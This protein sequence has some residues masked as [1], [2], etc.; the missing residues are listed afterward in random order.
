MRR[1][2]AVLFVHIG[3]SDKYRG[4]AVEGG[5]AFL[6]DDPAHR[7][8]CGEARLFEPDAQGFFQCGIGRH[9]VHADQAD[10]DIIFVA[11]DL[12]G[13]YRAVAAFFGA[14]WQP[15]PDDYSSEWRVA[16]ARDVVLLQTSMRPKLEWPFGQGMRR[17][18]QG[19]QTRDWKELLPT[20]DL[21]CSIRGF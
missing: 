21:L 12:T 1:A 14:S 13:T 3:W 9:E 5:H 20:Y 11:R 2:S 16:R 10:L 18:A 8:N 4:G 17:W 19:G 7:T 15:E 6:Q